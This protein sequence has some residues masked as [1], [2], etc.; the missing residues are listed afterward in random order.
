MK[1]SGLWVMKVSGLWVMKVSGLCVMKVS[2]LCVMKVSGLCP[3][4]HI[5]VGTMFSFEYEAVDK[6]QKP[7]NPKFTTF[8]TPHYAFYGDQQKETKIGWRPQ[9]ICKIQTQLV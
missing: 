4:P 3:S 8:C 5:L 7:N 9:N 6:S 2:G 1:V